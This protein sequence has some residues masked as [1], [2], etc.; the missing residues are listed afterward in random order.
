MANGHGGYRRPSNPAP[1]SGPGKLARRTDGG[2]GQPVRDLADARYGENKAYV[3]AQQA[4]PMSGG[5]S[6]PSMAGAGMGGL[7]DLSGITPFDAPS[8]RPEEDVM[9]GMP[10]GPGGGSTAS[11]MGPGNLTPEQAARLQSYL[12][13]LVILASQPDADPQTKK[14]VRQ[15]RGEL[16]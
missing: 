3:E 10:T 4:A 11:P 14:F 16:G 12:P 9:A 15:L 2:P 1:V 5:Q 7:P 6:A 8:A 13:V